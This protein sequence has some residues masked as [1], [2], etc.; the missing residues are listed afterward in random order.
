MGMI[1]SISKT[2]RDLSKQPLS[3]NNNNSYCDGGGSGSD[4]S[5]HNENVVNI[6]FLKDFNTSLGNLE[7]LS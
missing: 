1:Q 2:S 7:L 3:H 5:N 6:K 4:D